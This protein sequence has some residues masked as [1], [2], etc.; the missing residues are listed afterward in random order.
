MT[1]VP[2]DK[3]ADARHR[4]LRAAL[5][6]FAEAGFTGA[7]TRE[8]ARRA[9]VHQP[10]ILYHFQ[11]KDRLWK[12]AVDAIFSE[13]TKVLDTEL[14]VMTDAGQCRRRLIK[15]FITF[16]AR[17]PEWFTFIVHEGLQKNERTAWMVDRWLRP[18]NRKL[19]QTIATRPL[20]VTD[21]ADQLRAMSILGILTGATG[22]F[23]Q[24]SLIQQLTG[25]D[26]TDAAFIDQ[27]VDTVHTALNALLAD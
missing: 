25:L 17:N 5:S 23:A 10:A 4:I 15:I 3:A 18:L 16:V 24:K 21:T 11:N 8:I 14:P 20:P 27:H 1:P 13:F 12:A 26:V 6:V 2:E 22:V 7:S 9:G 19:Y